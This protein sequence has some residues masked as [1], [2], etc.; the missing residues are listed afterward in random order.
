MEGRR[1][2]SCAAAPAA[3]AES[4]SRKASSIV[5]IIVC[6]HE[7]RD[8]PTVVAERACGP[9]PNTSDEAYEVGPRSLVRLVERASV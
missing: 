6:V 4:P 5:V 3:A 7:P 9:A 2:L 1:G 8:P